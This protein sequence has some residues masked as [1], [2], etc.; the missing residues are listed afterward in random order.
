LRCPYTRILAY[1]LGF[2]LI[3]SYLIGE[4]HL[5]RI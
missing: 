3:F 1:L 5:Y 2:H 4:A